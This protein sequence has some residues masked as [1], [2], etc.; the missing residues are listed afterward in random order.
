MLR[1]FPR[2]TPSSAP[3]RSH[4]AR[5]QLQSSRLPAATCLRERQCDQARYATSVHAISNPTLAGIEKRWEEMPPREQA[6]LWMSLRDRMKVDWHEMTFREKQAGTDF[7]VPLQALPTRRS[8]RW[9]LHRHLA[10]EYL[11]FQKLR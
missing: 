9:C 10:K 7:Q 11:F 3:L 1:S 4:V 6:D 5:S 2:A 8:T